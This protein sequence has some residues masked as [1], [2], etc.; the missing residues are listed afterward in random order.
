MLISTVSERVCKV[1]QGKGKT[2][3]WQSLGNSYPI[4]RALSHTALWE[5][6]TPTP[7]RQEKKRNFHSPLFEFSPT[8]ACLC[9]MKIQL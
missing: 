6:Q 2:N 8:F 4:N 1:L 5:N 7:Q 3:Y 9:L